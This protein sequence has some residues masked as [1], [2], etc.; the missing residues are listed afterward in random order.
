VFLRFNPDFVKPR[1]G[2]SAYQSRDWASSTVDTCFRPGS[3][4]LGL[5]I[6]ESI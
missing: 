6:S 1:G 3:D 4:V 5:G 2:Q